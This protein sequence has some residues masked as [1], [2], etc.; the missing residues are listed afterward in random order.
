MNSFK[1]NMISSNRISKVLFLGLLG[2]SF[3][4]QAAITLDR[5]RTIFNG[6]DKSITI[7]VSNKNKK[8]PYLAQAWIENENNE[9][10]TSPFIIVPPLQRLEPEQSSQVRIEALSQIKDLPQDRESLF[11]FNLREIPPKSSKPNVL[12]I[13]LQSKIKLFYRPSSLTLTPN[14]LMNQPWQE[15]LVLLKNGNNFIAKNPTPYYTTIVSAGKSKSTPDIQDF[16]AV[17]IPPLSEKSLNVDVVSLGNMPVLTYVN[18]Y[19]GRKQMQF[20]CQMNE[21]SVIKT[22]QKGASNNE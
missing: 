10:V 16:Q 19:G 17:M 14:Q 3:S 18:D 9:K 15:N 12:Q 13:A 2:F 11:Y 4:S 6:S 20:Q 1:L 7:V 8:L 21:C 5:T 22:P